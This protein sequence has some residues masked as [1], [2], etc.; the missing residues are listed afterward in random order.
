VSVVLKGTGVRPEISISLDDGLLSFGNVIQNEFVEKT[1]SIKNVSSFPV[2]FEL[3]SK[4]QGVEN[5]SKLKTFTFIP[6]QGTIKANSDYPIK[7]LY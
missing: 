6:Q 2:N 1:F 7:I 3:I 5:K 4:V